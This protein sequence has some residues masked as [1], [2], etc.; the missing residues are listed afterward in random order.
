MRFKL[1]SHL[2]CPYVQR[3]AIVLEEKGVP[4]GRVNIDLTNKPEWFLKIS[5][6]GRV[7]LLV[8][9]N[10]SVLFESSVIAEFIDE[11]TGGGLLAT[12]TMQ[13]ARQ[14]QWIEFASAI[15]G[16]VYKVMIAETE[17]AFSTGYEELEKMWLT[18]EDH[19]SGGQFFSGEN[20]SLVDAAY[21]PALH[22][23]TVLEE[24]TDASLIQHMP[25]VCAWRG[26]LL[27]RKSV[28]DGIGE[29]NAEQMLQSLAAK[30]SI[31]GRLANKTVTGLD[32]TVA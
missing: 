6:L 7:P 8:I 21:A 2:L 16:N 11:S 29:N 1:I 26:T 31:A 5:P 15:L 22:N 17:E 10:E 32:R 24:L 18:V 28:H 20:F 30:D 14:R 9:D 3:S 25:R 23:C 12:D 19:H 13:K 4:Y 27:N